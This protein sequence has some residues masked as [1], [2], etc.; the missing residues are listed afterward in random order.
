MP[1]YLYLPTV[2]EE[3]LRHGVIPTPRT[4][5]EV[6]RGF[7]RDL[8]CYELRRLRDQMLRND[9]PKN[10]YADRVIELRTKYRVLSLRAREWVVQELR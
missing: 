9:F 8:Y 10:E 6:A 4:R 7:V 2:L 1:E 3:L 5:P